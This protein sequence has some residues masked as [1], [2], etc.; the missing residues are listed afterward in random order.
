MNTMVAPR[1]GRP[2]F[3]RRAIA[4]L[5]DGVALAAMSFVLLWLASLVLGEAVHIE[6]DRSEAPAVTVNSWRV[7]LN[8]V[9]LAGL[10]AAYF[11]VSWT[12]FRSS[13]GQAFLGIGVADA[14]GSGAMALS[15]A[16]A[17]F[18]WA[19]LGAP[20]GVAGAAA[21]NAPLAFLIVSVLSAGWFAVLLLTTLFSQSGRGLHDRLSRSDVI[22][23]R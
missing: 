19:L 18:R 13:P 17:L 9:L 20:L 8:A 1:G 23:S 12:H 7:V 11:V 5:L 10:S 21:V 22:R 6:L 16:R 15:T 2:R 4:F 14:A 3:W